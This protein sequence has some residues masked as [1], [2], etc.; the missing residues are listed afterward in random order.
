MAGRARHDDRG[1]SSVVCQ[2]ADRL[3]LRSRAVTR[4]SANAPMTARARTSIGKSPSREPRPGAETGP[5]GGVAMCR[6]AKGRPDRRTRV[7]SVIYD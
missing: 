2:V 1:G 3:G 5:N 7:V 4:H 6:T